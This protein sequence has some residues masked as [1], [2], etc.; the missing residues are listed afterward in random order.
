MKNNEKDEIEITEEMINQMKNYLVGVKNMIDHINK[1]MQCN[2][3]VNKK[4]AI[5]M[6]N[7]LIESVSGFVSDTDKINNKMLSLLKQCESMH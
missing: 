6:A 5:Y 7:E 4:L 2:N 3:G 1:E